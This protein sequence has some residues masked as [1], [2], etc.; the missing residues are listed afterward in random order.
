MN[1]ITEYVA[2]FIRRHTEPLEQRIKELE[3][4]LAEREKKIMKLEAALK[5]KDEKIE[6]LESEIYE[7]KTGERLTKPVLKKQDED[8]PIAFILNRG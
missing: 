4:L 7:L 1:E 6:R 5:E 2:E 3:M 8:D